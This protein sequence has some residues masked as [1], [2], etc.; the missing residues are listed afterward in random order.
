MKVG[1]DAVLLG[2][3]TELTGVKSV[4][5]VG[6]GCGILS[7]L[8]ASRELVS[9]DAVEKDKESFEEASENFA[10]SS[11]SDRLRISHSD[12][13]DFVLSSNKRYD[14]IISNPPFFINDLQSKNPKKSLARHTQSLSYKQLVNGA[15]TLLNPDG[16]IGVVLPYPESRF[17]L[18]TAKDAGFF[19][20]KKMLIFPVLGREPNRINLLLSSNPVDEQTEKFTIRDEDG[21]FTSQYVDFV[22]NY[23]LSV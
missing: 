11:F 8:L 9:V 10:K 4:L 7:L 18:K 16:K 3:W 22:K 1:T 21:K 15:R 12:F 23:Y 6:A 17:F 14:L 2:I 5:E 20:E 13:N 19:V